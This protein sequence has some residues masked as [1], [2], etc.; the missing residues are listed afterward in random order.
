MAGATLAEQ[1]STLTL[2]ASFSNTPPE[3]LWRNGTPSDIKQLWKDDSRLEAWERYRQHLAGQTK[4]DDLKAALAQ[5]AW[6]L[7]AQHSDFVVSL[8]KAAKRG[9]LSDLDGAATD[10]L[11]SYSS[12][13]QAGPLS[14]SEA[15]DA[16]AWATVL[17]HA[18]ASL[19]VELWLQVLD[20][21]TGLAQ[22]AAD[23][24]RSLAGADARSVLAE[25]LIA[26]ELTTVLAHRLS[27]LRPLHILC[28]A[29]EAALT[30]ALVEL[31]DG[32]GILAS[33][34]LAV[35]SALFG[36]WT[37]CRLLNE[38]SD[39][40]PWSKEAQSQ[41]EWLIRFLLRLSGEDGDLLLSDC[42]NIED[43][44]AEALSLDGDVADDAAAE[45]RLRFDLDAE[46][47]KPPEPSCESEWAE[48][49]VLAAGWSPKSPVIAVAWDQSTMRLAIR[50]DNRT[51]IEGDWPIVVRRDGQL[52]TTADE[53][54]SQ[55][56]YSDED[57]DYL[58]VATELAD[59]VRLE[60]QI[61]LGRQHGV[62]GVSELIF[63]GDEA[64][65]EVET[66]LQL[67][68]GIDYAPEAETHDGVVSA[69]KSAAAAIFPCSLPEWRS[70]PN[71]GDLSM[72][73]QGV[74]CLRT[75]AR[76]RNLSSLLWIDL[77]SK[78]F[79]KQR[80][81]RRL[82]VAQSLE[83]VGRDVAVGYRIQSGKDQW[84]YYRSLDDA[85]NRTVLGQNLSSEG[86]V[87]RLLPTGEVDEYFE[88]EAED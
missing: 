58:E 62:V 79:K 4:K 40:G 26:G 13:L 65:W 73:D 47:E 61:V 67:S 51:L 21:L 25:N 12:L 37:R 30:E 87:G 24:K 75:A 17:T 11:D 5:L 63:G 60:R 68:E 54:D 20:A 32:E 77:S 55:C 86:F 9:K 38:S 49:A 34:L 43:A 80:T 31:T 81:W 69:G 72:D 36:S 15:L 42:S 52:L 71:E 88:I 56:W 74:L 41:Y 35:G 85:A 14:V 83:K 76:G 46:D 84:L 45:R 16:V 50:S 57:C 64:E 70:E 44:L 28:E 66:K 82:T 78:R 33:R 23:S 39:S 29:G 53:W 3:R 1:D 10:W 19:P 48:C 8:A 22:S 27:E 7:P 2:P 59:G 6:G 18:P